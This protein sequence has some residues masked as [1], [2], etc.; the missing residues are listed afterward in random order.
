MRSG[1]WE[2]A[3]EGA[4]LKGRYRLDQRVGEGGMGMVFRSTAL[5]SE[6]LG[7]N[8]ILAVKVLKPSFRSH[9]D[10][11]RA[12]NEE[13]RKARVV[14]HPNIVAAYSFNRDQH[15]VFMTMEFFEGKPLDVL[16]DEEFARGMP[17]D[18]AWPITEGIGGALAYSHDRHRGPN[19]CASA[20]LW[21]E[22][23]L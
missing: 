10:A 16:H 21:H 8:E 19:Q 11:L 23:G 4:V 13:V 3:K 15:Q 6:G 17:F 22:C 5:E 18:R 2:E 7:G 14:A 20:R 1:V 9:P 12:L